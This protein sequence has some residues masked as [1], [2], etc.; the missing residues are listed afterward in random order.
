M[1]EMHSYNIEGKKAGAADWLRVSSIRRF[2]LAAEALPG[3]SS[4]YGPGCRDAAPAGG[5]RTVPAAAVR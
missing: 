4:S 3:A 5:V 2:V 1:S